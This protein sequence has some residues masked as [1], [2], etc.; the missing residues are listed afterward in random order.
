METHFPNIQES[1]SHRARERVLSDLKVLANDAE[2]LLRATAD[3]VGGKASEARARLS[4]ALEKAKA[5]YSE[6]Q[7]FAVDAAK[8]TAR[9]ADATVRAHPYE[10]VGIAF[11]VGVLL[12]LL[13]RRK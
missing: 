10:A 1:R 3:D 6:V 13:L 7:E 8:E 5:T 4:A 2:N 11:G 9:K 12:G